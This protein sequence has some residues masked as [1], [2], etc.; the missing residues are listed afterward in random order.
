MSTIS[1]RSI[2]HFYSQ[3]EYKTYLRQTLRNRGSTVTFFVSDSLSFIF[4][5][6]VKRSPVADLCCRQ[7][8]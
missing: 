8:L 4:I 3:F 2:E 5:M 1:Y 6:Y 7:A